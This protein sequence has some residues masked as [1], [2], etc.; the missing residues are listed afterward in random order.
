MSTTYGTGLHACP[1]IQ[2]ELDNYFSTCSNSQLR[3]PMP[4]FDM[5]WSPMNRSS[6]QQLI[7]PGMGKNRTVQLRYDQR[8]GEDVVE[9]VNDCEIACTADNVFGDLTATYEIDPCDKL[10]VGEKMKSS[11]FRQACRSNPEIIAGKIQRLID[12]MVRKA[13]TRLT[14]K[15]VLLRGKWSSEVEDVQAGDW[16]KV[17]TLKAGSDNINPRTLQDIEFALKQ[18]NFCNGAVLI[19]GSEIYKYVELMQSGCC[20]NEG[21]ALDS[22]VSRWGLAGMYDM[23]VNTLIG[24]DKAWLIQPGALQPIYYVDSDNQVAESV[25]V[26]VG[27]DYQKQI[28]FDPQSGLPMDMLISDHCGTVSIVLETVVDLVGMPSDMFG[29]TDHMAEVNYFTGLQNINS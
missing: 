24:K 15:A 20:S 3:E 18:T 25:G 19:S 16:L 4:F 21:L 28:V 23:R 2:T 27:A 1:D 7:A 26:D 14:N 22:I 29:P 8:L 13:A 6:I 17:S 11:Y 10:R 5:L 12:V 9:E